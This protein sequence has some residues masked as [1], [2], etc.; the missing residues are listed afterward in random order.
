MLKLAFTGFG[1]EPERLA[2]FEHHSIFLG[3]LLRWHLL[4]ILKLIITE[5]I[6]LQL[7]DVDVP[8]LFKFIN[9]LHNIPFEILILD[10]F[11]CFQLWIFR[12]I[13]C[14]T[15]IYMPVLLHILQS[16]LASANRLVSYYFKE[17]QFYQVTSNV[18]LYQD[19]FLDVQSIEGHSLSVYFHRFEAVGGYVSVPFLDL[20]SSYLLFDVSEPHPYLRPIVL[21]L[22]KP[23]AYPI[24]DN[25]L[26]HS[27]I[28][29]PEL[30]DHSNASENLELLCFFLVLQEAVLLIKL[31]H[32][33]IL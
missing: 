3:Q 11:S 8:T 29:P 21:S 33:N 15:S 13:L 23:A 31:L 17:I 5:F 10:F 19:Q 26:A 24:A 1:I 14:D 4:P 18:W 27:I 2:P 22:L 12:L 6:F 32:V 20:L 28:K 30:L 25:Y 9:R 16:A 7:L